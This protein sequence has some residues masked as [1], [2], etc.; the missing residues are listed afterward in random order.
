MRLGAVVTVSLLVGGAGGYLLRVYQDSV[1]PEKWHET[2]QMPLVGPNSGLSYST[3]AMFDSDIPLPAIAN[4]SAKAKFRPSSDGANKVT[5]GYV[6]VVTVENLKA[7]NIPDG[8][9]VPKTER[10]GKAGELTLLPPKEV[11]YE[12]HLSFTLK[13]KDGFDLAVVNGKQHSLLSGQSNVLQD[14]IDDALP[15]EVAQRT[16]AIVPHLSVDKCVTCR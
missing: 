16:T 11:V 14:L 1:V 8:Y 6:V 3:E 4:V 7:E 15:Q 9:K 13:D 5:L 12:M 2:A 10:V